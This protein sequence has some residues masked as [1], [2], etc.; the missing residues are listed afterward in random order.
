MLSCHLVTP[1][2]G[3]ASYNHRYCWLGGDICRPSLWL[4][5][6]FLLS[7][8]P[9][10]QETPAPHLPLLTQPAVLQVPGRQVPLLP[11]LEERQLLVGLG[12]GSLLGGLFCITSVCFCSPK[13]LHSP[14]CPWHTRERMGTPSTLEEPTGVC[15]GGY[16]LEK[17]ASHAWTA[18][19]CDV[20]FLPG[21]CPSCL[22][23]FFLNHTFLATGPRGHH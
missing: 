22:C 9:L 21:V 5:D 19:S 20:A 16:G 13:L 11:G 18:S 17:L 12:S 10:L 6:G 4:M 8:G 14:P 7:P 3:V 23:P 2:L 15:R 1:C